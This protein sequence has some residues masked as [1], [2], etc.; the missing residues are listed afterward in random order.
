MC[1]LMLVSRGMLLTGT[2]WRGKIGLW[3]LHSYV[4]AVCISMRDQSP[5]VLYT[6]LSQRESKYSQRQL[7]SRAIELARAIMNP[8][9]F[10]NWLHAYKERLETSEIVGASSEFVRERL[11]ALFVQDPPLGTISETSDQI[12]FKMMD[13]DLFIR[14]INFDGRYVEHDSALAAFKKQVQVRENVI[15]LNTHVRMMDSDHIMQTLE[16]VRE[17]PFARMPPP[18]SVEQA[19]DTQTSRIETIELDLR[20]K[21]LFSQNELLVSVPSGIPF[22]K[23]LQTFFSFP[24]SVN[25]SSVLSF[26]IFHPSYNRAHIATL[27][28]RTLFNLSDDSNAAECWSRYKQVIVVRPDDRE[29]EEYRRRWGATHVIVA[30]PEVM[31][32][33][34]ENKEQSVQGGGIGYA[35]LFIQ[36]FV[37]WVELDHCWIIDDNIVLFREL[38]VGGYWRVTDAL[39][40]LKRI[41][42]MVL[43]ISNPLREWEG[44]D[45][46]QI[47]HIGEFRQHSNGAPISME[48]PL[49]EFT[50][51]IDQFA[52]IGLARAINGTDIVK[53][54]WLNTRAVYSCYLL[55]V[56]T[57]M[58][59]KIEFPPRPTLEDVEFNTLCK[60]A[61]LF[62]VKSQVL[63][64]QKGKVKSMSKGIRDFSFQE[65]IAYDMPTD[66]DAPD[67]TWDDVRILVNLVKTTSIEFHIDRWILATGG[68]SRDPQNIKDV[69]NPSYALHLVDSSYCAI[70][71]TPRHMFDVT[72]RQ[73]NSILNCYA[74]EDFE[75]NVQYSNAPV[76]MICSN[77][78]KRKTPST[79]EDT[80]S[81]TKF[82]K[83]E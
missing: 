54:H 49:H 52:L 48:S 1:N 62:T 71:T 9:P 69:D 66:E 82:R 56:K 45:F 14:C 46:D 34:Q 11:K 40:A 68:K 39:H 38:T 19:S 20:G 43:H 18:L 30:M 50:G 60:E 70:I 28:Y 59:K 37:H 24:K 64:Y 33:G 55:N 83:T 61:D 80:V 7:N 67:H 47:L 13:T 17:E 26:P 79:P 4:N 3:I 27:D 23:N 10:N 76:V 78:H 63:W 53:N 8:S 81:P 2:P 12:S 5:T 36:R 41:E 57:T 16:Q 29:F 73:Q 21:R 35:R 32:Y 22:D 42:D 74:F 6:N 65:F 72:A 77:S 25:T 58:S 44:A 15:T 31:S 51:D 75:F